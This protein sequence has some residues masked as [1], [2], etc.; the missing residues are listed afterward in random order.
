MFKNLLL[1]NKSLKILILINAVFLLG[2]SMFPPI[3]ALFVEEIGGNAFTAGSIWATFAI[4]TGFL[5][6][7]ISRYGDKLKEREYLVAAGYIFRCLAWLGYFFVN[8]LWQ[9]YF[10]QLILAL[11]ESFGTPAFLGIYSEH[12]DKGRHI[13]QW[14]VYTSFTII[15]G[16][17]AAFLGGAI[18]SQF[19]FRVLFLVMTSLSALAF[20]LL[21]I[22]PRKLL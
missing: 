14:G 19:G 5:M 22:Q 4:G 8:S 1:K 12:L 18:V 2:A 17:V 20:F 13:R 9:L 3:F 16:G 15:I 7:I 11:G 10:L 21:I 6:L